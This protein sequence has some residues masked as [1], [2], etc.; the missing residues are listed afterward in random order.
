MPTLPAH[1]FTGTDV[2]MAAGTGDVLTNVEH[3]PSQAAF[4]QLALQA[5]VRIVQPAPVDYPPGRVEDLDSIG[6]LSRS[7]IEE[8]WLFG[9]HRSEFSRNFSGWTFHLLADGH[10]LAG[11]QEAVQVGFQ[12]MMGK[13]G[14]RNSPVPAR[15]SQAKNP[16]SGFRILAV[17]LVKIAHAKK[18]KQIGMPLLGRVVLLNQCHFLTPVLCSRAAGPMWASTRPL[19]RGSRERG[20]QPG[21]RRA[22]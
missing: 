2:E 5:T 12:L 8:S 15:Q 19:K 10:T 13:T 18:Q 7:F 17:Q 6:S 1:P 4:R 11:L 22:V 9:V 20:G 14:H 21:L 16:G 3:Q